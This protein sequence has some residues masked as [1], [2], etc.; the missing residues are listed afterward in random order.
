LTML[1]GPV[2]ARIEPYCVCMACRYSCTVL[3]FAASTSGP[4]LPAYQFYNEVT[5]V[6]RSHEIKDGC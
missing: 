1:V 4:M 2:K 5:Y 6:H 3:F